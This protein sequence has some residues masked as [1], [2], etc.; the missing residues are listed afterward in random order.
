MERPNAFQSSTATDVTATFEARGEA[1]HPPF[2]L[3]LA[4]GGARGLAHAGVLRALHHYGYR[5]SAIVGVSMGA[6][7]GATYALNPDWYGELLAMDTNG[8]PASLTPRRADLRERLR[9]LGASRYALWRMLTSWA[10][11]R[12]KERAAPARPSLDA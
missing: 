8:F 7:V 5:P 11:V 1:S 6:V 12:G 2:A 10:G 9:A 4:G 3:V